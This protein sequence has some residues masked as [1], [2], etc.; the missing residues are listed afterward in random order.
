MYMFNVSTLYWIVSS[1]TL[2]EFD[3]PIKALSMHIQKS[4]RITKEKSTL[5]E[6]AYI[7]S[8]VHVDMNVFA[9]IKI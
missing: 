2:V 1:K 3:R 8:I 4:L 6:L 7:I 9:I 5:I